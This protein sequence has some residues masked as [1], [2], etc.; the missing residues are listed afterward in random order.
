MWGVIARLRD[1]TGLPLA[2][3]EQTALLHEQ[4]ALADARRML[5]DD[6]FDQ[7][8]REGSAMDLEEAVR[9]ALGEQAG[10]DT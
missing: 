4:T 3:H 1:E 2:F 8:W 7:A 5:G 10:R 6:A 9:H